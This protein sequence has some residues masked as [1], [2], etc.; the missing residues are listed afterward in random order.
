[1]AGLEESLGIV[2]EEV[3]EAEFTPVES[4]P[5]KLNELK[6]LIV[7]RKVPERSINSALKGLGI[8]SIEKLSDEQ[9]DKWSNH[10]KAKESK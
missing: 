6:E 1:M 3:I 8:D 9:I 7:S 5:S 10:L 4:S 2:N